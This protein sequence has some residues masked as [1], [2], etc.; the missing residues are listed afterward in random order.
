MLKAV[1]VIAYQNMPNF[2]KPT[3]FAIQDSYKL[4]PYSTVIGMV[5]TA[6][7]FTEYHP[8]RVSI[9]GRYHNTMV[10][11]YTRYFFGMSLEYDSKAGGYTRHQLYTDKEE[12]GGLGGFTSGLAPDGSTAK[13]KDGITRGLGYAELVTDL[14]LAIYIVPDNPDELELIKDGLTYPKRFPALGR[15]E[16]ILRMDNVEIVELKQQSD[17]DMDDGQLFH[18]HYDALVPMDIYSE[19]SLNCQGTV[20]SLNKCF[21]T[22]DAKGVELKSRRITER[23]TAKLIKAGTAFAAKAMYD[24]YGDDKIG[25]FLA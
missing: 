15:H 20:Y 4:P 18:M 12:G 14:E 1:R 11:M 2:R 16:D 22:K 19:L 13:N 3:S 25:V 23:V 6:C 7:G 10:D 8:M 17:N 21:A 9:A 24:E 5:H